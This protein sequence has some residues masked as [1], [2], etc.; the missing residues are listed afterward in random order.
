VP[1]LSDANVPQI[2]ADPVAGNRITISRRTLHI[3]E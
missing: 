3:P 2:A 1:D